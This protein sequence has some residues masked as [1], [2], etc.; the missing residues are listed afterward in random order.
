MLQ[1]FESIHAWRAYTA[2]AGSWT[3]WL[4]HPTFFDQWKNFFQIHNQGLASSSVSC[5]WRWPEPST[6]SAHLT[7][8]LF[9]WAS[10]TTYEAMFRALQGHR[11]GLLC[12]LLL[13]PPHL[14]HTWQCPCCSEVSNPCDLP[15]QRRPE[16]KQRRTSSYDSVQTRFH[17]KNG[18]SQDHDLTT[19]MSKRYQE[20]L[21][22]E[23]VSA[24]KRNFSSS[25]L[26]LIFEFLDF[27]T[28]INIFRLPKRW[29]R[30]H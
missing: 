30:H 19:S 13:S 6:P 4:P 14:T 15:E 27:V 22:L 23:K 5:F 10:E 29:K 21:R 25:R 17:V 24:K 18:L 28:S 3:G 2:K 8:S 1:L 26:C 20:W 16:Y 11:V 9:H 12:Q 7:V